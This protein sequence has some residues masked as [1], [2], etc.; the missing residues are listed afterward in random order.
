MMMMIIIQ[1][2]YSDPLEY[3]KLTFINRHQH[4][5][6]KISTRKANFCSFILNTFFFDFNSI[7]TEKKLF[8]VFVWRLVCVYIHDENIFLN[9]YGKN[10]VHRRM[11]TNIYSDISLYS[12]SRPPVLRLLPLRLTLL[13]SLTICR[14]IIIPV[15]KK[16][17]YLLGRAHK[18]PAS[19]CGGAVI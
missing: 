2:M 1:R 5:N 12:P 16:G 19:S 14:T 4:E 11:R 6:T 9:Y 17:K 7:N 8:S 10:I 13:F 18:L 15:F 3:F